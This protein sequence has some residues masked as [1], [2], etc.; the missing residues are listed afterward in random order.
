MSLWFVCVYVNKNSIMILS[1]MQQVSNNRTCLYSKPPVGP[2]S[3]PHNW[4]TM[5]RILPA[6]TGNSTTDTSEHLVPRL[7]CKNRLSDGLWHVVGVI[8][9]LFRLQGGHRCIYIAVRVAGSKLWGQT[10]AFNWK[11][12]GV[13]KTKRHLEY[14]T[15]IYV[16]VGM[17]MLD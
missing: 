14:R 6:N 11:L 4:K 9:L 7:H 8:A 12:A 17:F 2:G 10:D 16:S 5:C 3:A 1:C 15:A 13:R